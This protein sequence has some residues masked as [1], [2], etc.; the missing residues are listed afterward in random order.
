MSVCM[1]AHARTRRARTHTHARVRT[2]RPAPLHALA[3]RPATFLSVSA[4]KLHVRHA[5]GRFSY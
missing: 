2:S 3:P 1:H 5:M 4:D